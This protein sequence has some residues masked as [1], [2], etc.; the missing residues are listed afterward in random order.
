MAH[1]YVK[2]RPARILDGN[3]P[4]K[5]LL[6]LISVY[7]IPVKVCS[8]KLTSTLPSSLHVSLTSCPVLLFERLQVD[9]KA[10]LDCDSPTSCI[11]ISSSG[12]Q[13]CIDMSMLDSFIG[14]CD[15]NE[16][17]KLPLSLLKRLICMPTHAEQMNVS[18]SYHF[19]D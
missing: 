15:D 17:L 5:L 4:S 11:L 7:D 1:R 9:F 18:I 3:I 2:Q 6:G 12:T 13:E 16:S 14:D 10:D 8:P 19:A